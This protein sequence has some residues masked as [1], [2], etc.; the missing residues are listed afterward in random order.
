M[1]LAT[2][3][4]LGFLSTNRAEEAKD[5][6]DAQA[7]VAPAADANVVQVAASKVDVRD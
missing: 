5:A 7:K 2:A 4:L 3:A 6:R 1:L